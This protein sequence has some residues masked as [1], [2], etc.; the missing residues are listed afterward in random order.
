[1]ESYSNTE[2]AY[3]DPIARPLVGRKGPTTGPIARPIEGWKGPTTDPL[4]HPIA[5]WKGPTKLHQTGKY[6]PLNRI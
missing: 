3:T 5:G 6:L 2:S 4:A 1:M